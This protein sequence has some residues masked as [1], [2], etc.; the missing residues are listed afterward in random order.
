VL[1]SRRISHTAA[2]YTVLFEP[3]LL[4]PLGPC[5]LPVIH[6]VAGSSSSPDESVDTS[7]IKTRTVMKEDSWEMFRDRDGR[8][9]W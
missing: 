9:F 4:S 7:V 1:Q 2:G 8:P 6:V 5:F 3:Y